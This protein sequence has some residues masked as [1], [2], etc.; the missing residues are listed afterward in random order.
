M[1]STVQS[2]RPG[3]VLL[4][5]SLFAL[6]GATGFATQ[7]GDDWPQ[8]RGRNV[9]G[10]STAQ[11][12]FEPGKI[13]ALE[14]SWMKPLGSGYS[15][16]AVAS[17]LAVTMFT[18]GES[19]VLIAFDAAT[20][21]ERWRFPF[22][23]IYKGHDGSYDGPIST[24]VI[25]GNLTVALGPSGRL[26]ALDNLD[27]ELVWSHDLVE[28]YDAPAP[29]YGYATS[30]IVVDGTAVVQ[31]GAKVGTV[32][33]FDVETGERRWVLGSDGVNAQSPIPMTLNGRRQILASGDN[34]LYALDGASG[35]MLWSYDHGGG[36]FIGAMT[37]VPVAAG[38]DRLFLNYKDD[39]ST[40]VA[41]NGTGDARAPAE[42][43][44][45]RTIRNTYAP[46]V[47]HD[48]HLYGFSSRFLTCVDA[49]TGKAV[50]KS[51][52]PG[53]G[54]LILVDGHLVIVTKNGSVHVAKASPDGYEEI[55]S[56]QIF[57]DLAWTPPSF[58]D[59]SLFA[60]SLG[61]IA[62][63]EL[64][65]LGEVRTTDED[66]ASADVDGAFEAFLND[67][68][69]SDDKAAVIDAFFAEQASFPI[70]EGDRVHF[71]Y[72]GEAEDMAVAGDMFG[73]RQEQRMTRVEGTDLFYLTIE[74]RPD[75]QISYLFIKDFQDS[76]IDPLNPAAAQW[77]LIGKDMR[78]LLTP[79]P[80]DVSTLTMPEWVEP[81][82]RSGNGDTGAGGRLETHE[83][84]SDAMSRRHQI[85]VYLPAGY[86]E[87][88]RRYPVVYVHGGTLAQNLGQITDTLDYLIAT[89]KLE[90]VI[91]VLIDIGVNHIFR[92]RDA[93]GE[94][95]AGE[96]VPFID[97]SYRTLTGR[98]A[99]ANVGAS[100]A[101]HDAAHC[102]FRYPE[103]SSKLAV[104]SIT[105]LDFGWERLEPLIP[106]ESEHAFDIH[107]EWGA[108]DIRNPQEAWDV[109]DT[110]RDFASF[111]EGRGFDVATFEAPSGTG[112]PSW[113][114][115]SDA[116]LMSLYPVETAPEE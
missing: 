51:R 19:N 22:S 44:E 77:A 103:L 54:F 29:L 86:D 100:L 78:I 42:L 84:A 93:Y 20:G 91:A 81:P 10:I 58:A 89:S 1:N 12:V 52:P 47:Y 88:D 39:S 64:D 30:P 40:V 36:D 57:E 43:W 95:W 80:M 8:F 87:S 31:V 24:P 14:A 71:V 67:V 106:T 45:A 63:I 33:G 111:L 50:W 17:G 53:D 104:Q 70:V 94:M 76:L 18:D 114:N 105:L 65:A 90:P 7:D 34:T 6:V 38:P 15:G 9:D 82:H 55:A 4:L 98:D 92:P 99:R 101:A 102:A 16:I 96:L 25:D 56:R 46:A 75:V 13:P 28:D 115:R 35:E 26:F 113:R 27:G 72:R 41:L 116:V 3:L 48:G 61:A 23:D 32:A 69:A 112:W 74:I 83:L 60:R 109:R 59:G 110:T 73:A 2:A 97:R 37:I 11:D 68:G 49:S 79:E 5:L 62:R 21:S 85:Q 107:V 66:M 108:Y